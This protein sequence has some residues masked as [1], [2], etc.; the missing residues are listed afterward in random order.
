MQAN[1][2]NRILRFAN[3]RLVQPIAA[4]LFAGLLF[5]TAGAFDTE[6]VRLGPRLSYWLAIAATST[7]ALQQL[8]R[9][10]ETIFDAVPGLWLR[11]CGWAVLALPLNALASLGCKVLFGGAPSL[12]GFLLL[13]PGMSMILAALQVTLLLFE[14]RGEPRSSERDERCSQVQAA[15]PRSLA[16][17]LPL[18]LQ[19][20]AIHAV[21]AEDHYVRVHTDGGQALLRMRMS[22]AV[23][24]LG[25]E[26]DGIRPH[27]SW[28]V[29]RTAV[30]GLRTEGGRTFIRLPDRTS[31][32]VSRSARPSLGPLF[33]DVTRA[34]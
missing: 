23:A 17:F 29:A 1:S 33:G 20:C 31:V 32:P 2:V 28:W 9:L 4:A 16:P 10:L 12:T 14:A 8:H 30:S 7:L 13:L 11:A 27:R 24:I 26:E 19:A 3:P 21:S 18:P 25:K 5:S 6:A 22:D 15:P 34:K